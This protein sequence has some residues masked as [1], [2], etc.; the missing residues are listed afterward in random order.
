MPSICRLVRS[1]IWRPPHG[2]A[3]RGSRNRARHA[4]VICQLSA[5]VVTPRTR[6]LVELKTVLDDS[7]NVEARCP[8][9]TSSVEPRQQRTDVGA[10]EERLR[11]PLD[12]GE[13]S[14]AGV[15]RQALADARGQEPRPYAEERVEDRD[16]DHGQGE[17]YHHAGVLGE[18][19]VVEDV[20][21]QQQIGHRQGQVEHGQDIEG[22]CRSSACTARRSSCRGGL[23]C[24]PVLRASFCS[25][26]D[27]SRRMVRIIMSGLIER[28]GVPPA[29]YIFDVVRS[30]RPLDVR[31]WRSPR[32]RRTGG[33]LA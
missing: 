3:S 32:N 11:Y 4:R 15:E 12:V 21:D 22:R 1:L 10:D 25:T 13:G 7:V 17:L 18:D 20:L 8:P 16:Q 2:E 23:C 19:A 14:G 29:G 28:T 27:R 24:E 6:A 33:R 9:I 30:E 5:N 31:R 26:N